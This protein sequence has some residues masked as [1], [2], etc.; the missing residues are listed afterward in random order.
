MY[1]AIT[2]PKI[3]EKREGHEAKNRGKNRDLSKR[4]AKLI[5]IQTMARREK[6]KEEEEDARSR[7]PWNGERNYFVSWRETPRSR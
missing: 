7:N 1:G 3:E 2:P 4:V 6:R 5:N